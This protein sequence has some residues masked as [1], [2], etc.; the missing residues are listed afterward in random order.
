MVD[1]DDFDL[2]FIKLRHQWIEILFWQK[3]ETIEAEANGHATIVTIWTFLCDLLEV[4]HDIACKS[5]E[6]DLNR[7]P[8]GQLRHSGIAEYR[9]N[10]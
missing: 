3:G 6:I 2:E 4:F 5:V 9:S 1:C 7:L 10:P 8:R